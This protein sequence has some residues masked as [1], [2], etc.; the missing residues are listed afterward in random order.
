ML[1]LCVCKLH[2]QLLTALFTPEKLRYKA[3][4]SSASLLLLLLLL[5]V[6]VT[7]R[8]GVLGVIITPD[9]RME[10]G[11][12]GRVALRQQLVRKV[13]V[14]DRRD[15]HPREERQRQRHAVQ[16]HPVHDGGKGVEEDA[17]LLVP[18]R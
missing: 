9:I 15:V 2:Q 14:E 1:V 17:V 16:H 18:V 3:A 13:A 7:P 6:I 12:V 10:P 5:G 11:V 8:M 4:F